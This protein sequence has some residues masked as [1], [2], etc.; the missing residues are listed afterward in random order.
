MMS[1]TY[2]NAVDHLRFSE[3]LSARVMEKSA[4][5]P[6]FRILR[7]AVVTAIVTVLLAGTAFAI[8]LDLREQ[9]I[10]KVS[11]GTSEQPFIDAKIM[12][13]TA[14]EEVEGVSIHYLE[15]PSNQTYSFVHGMLYSISDGFFRI[16]QNY[17]LEKIKS[18]TVEIAFEKNGWTYSLDFAYV[19][20]EK[21]I[22]SPHK[23]IYHKNENSEIMLNASSAGSFQWPVYVNLETGTV[24]DA[25]PNFT[26]DD[27]EGREIYA[28]EFRG[29]ILLSTI[30]NEATSNGRNVIYWIANASAKP[31]IIKFPTQ[32]M[33]WDVQ[34]DTIYAQDSA[35]R[36]YRM[37]DEF[38][39]DKVSDYR[40]KDDLTHGLLTVRTKNR[41]LAVFDILSNEVYAISG[42]LV[43]LNDLNETFGYNA[44]RY[45]VNGK[46]SLVHTFHDYENMQTSI[47]QI[48]IL[49]TNSGTLRYLEIDN[50]FDG[51]HNHWLDE[52][53]FGVLYQD[54]L[55]RYLCIYEFE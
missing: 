44:S 47:D 31:E 45:S 54:G 8:N 46:I 23:D 6:K 43:D 14:S 22:V 48:G 53:R 51:Y 12:T 13:F 17:Q 11:L 52:N 50:E 33:R 38:A 49:D 1:K 42:L 9:N 32:S 35:G 15:L 2:K 28:W 21:G 40:T 36:L 5:K 41:E 19:D 10:Q 3:N 37:D 26:T 4:A 20:T 27:F 34:N 7:V 39:F 18:E 24:R 55:K 30:V 29:G 25:L 16:T